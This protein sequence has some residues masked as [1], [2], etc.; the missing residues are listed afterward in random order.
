MRNNKIINKKDAV[1]VSWC[2]LLL[3]T[4]LIF[5]EHDHKVNL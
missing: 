2:V 5:S 4:F 1:S 3:S